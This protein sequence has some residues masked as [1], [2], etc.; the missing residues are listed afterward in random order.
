MPP[1]APTTRTGRLLVSDIDGASE[2]AALSLGNNLVDLGVGRKYIL[3]E[4]NSDRKFGILAIMYG[5]LKNAAEQS[6]TTIMKNMIDI[7]I[8]AIEANIS[9][10]G[11]KL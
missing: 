11:P 1:V 4:T 10:L 2:K 7:G 3:C 9:G 6:I 5:W 8:D